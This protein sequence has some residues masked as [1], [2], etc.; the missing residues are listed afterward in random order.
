MVI[1]MAVFGD[2]QLHVVSPEKIFQEVRNDHFIFHYSIAKLSSKQKTTKS[3]FLVYH[4]HKK[5]RKFPF[6][7]NGRTEL[8][9]PKRQTAGENR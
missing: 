9:L 5:I 4:L 6:N 8:D 3:C 7:V 1:K 2:T